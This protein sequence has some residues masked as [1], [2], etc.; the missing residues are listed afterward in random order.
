VRATPH[1]IRAKQARDAGLFFVGA[2]RRNANGLS[3]PHS[4]RV[5]VDANSFSQGQKP[6]REFKPAMSMPATTRC[7]NQRRIFR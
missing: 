6:M 5:Q 3:Q 1:I 7:R 2:A 4:W